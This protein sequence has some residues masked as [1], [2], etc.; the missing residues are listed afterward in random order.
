MPTDAG[1]LTAF[2]SHHDR[3]RTFP[4]SRTSVLLAVL[5]G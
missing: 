3:R 4:L 1:A 5:Y 2:C